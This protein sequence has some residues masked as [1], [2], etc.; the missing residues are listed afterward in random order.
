V[1]A[2][3]EDPEGTPDTRLVLLGDYI[4]RGRFSFDGVLRAAMRLFV[5]APHAVYVLRGNHE[6]YLEH[7]G[8]ILAPVRP[9]E[10]WTSV[11]GIAPEGF[12][13][14]YR[15][16]FEAL[17]SMLA[18]DRLFFVHAGVPRDD[19]LAE[20]YKDLASLND[21][22]LRFQMLWSDPA[23]TEMVPAELQAS[24]SRFAFG[25]HQL[26]S[27]LRRIGCTTMIRGHE[28]V[29]EG[30]RTV[31][32][33]G[34]AALMTLFSAGGASNADLPESSNYREVTPM[35]LTIRHR[36][37]LSR[38]TPFTIDYAKYNQPALNR[39]YTVPVGE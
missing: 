3:H 29:V 7:Q 5:A 2:H 17:P 26:R 9:A 27:F 35:G 33:Q 21:P 8:R 20:R 4:D 14:E 32:D 16:L 6:Y 10:A 13:G 19:L 38:V 30:F 15:R 31:H 25:T 28:R 1:Q 18:F 12:L 22:D 11:Q 36:D 23:E 39:F 34:N 24:T 37:G